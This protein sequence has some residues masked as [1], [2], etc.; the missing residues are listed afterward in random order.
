MQKSAAAT[1]LPVSTLVSRTDAVPLYHQIFLALRDQIMHGQ[2]PFGSPVPTEQEL[3]EMH[4]VSRITARRALHEL[5]ES[6]LVERK[7]RVGT[8]VVFRTSAMPLEANVNQA[9]E[10]L[11]AFGRNTRVKV[12][13]ITEEPAP[14][15]VA[16]ALER[17]ADSM[18]TRARRIRH[19]DRE[20]LGLV[21]SWVPR[22]LGIRL[23]R[24]I[25]TSQPI[26]D[27]LRENGFTP[28][29][30]RQTI[31]A[32]HADPESAAL[33]KLEQRAALLRIERVVLDQHNRPILLTVA[34]YRADRYKL[35]LDLHNVA[36]PQVI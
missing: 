2:L 13:D 16:D 31:S 11:I 35:S 19:L 3:V 32:R 9:V 20:P 33:L 26:L 4:G 25:L 14:R 7:R 28:G 24:Q 36:N 21:T 15:Q 18:M 17:P 5:A 12:V 23:T 27:V 34:D 6:G 29:S 1:D 30:G 8:R 10:S 22:D